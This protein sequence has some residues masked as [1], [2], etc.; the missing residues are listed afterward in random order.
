MIQILYHKLETFRRRVTFHVQIILIFILRHFQIRYATM[1]QHHPIIHIGTHEIGLSQHEIHSILILYHARLQFKDR[2]IDMAD[3]G[4][5]PFFITIPGL[6]DRT[7]IPRNTRHLIRILVGRNTP[8]L[9]TLL[10]QIVHVSLS[11]IKVS[12]NHR[13]IVG[14]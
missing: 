8:S 6:R 1:M 10:I 7:Q 5:V 12:P 4:I 2:L 11:Q 9:K 13:L 3:L 14:L